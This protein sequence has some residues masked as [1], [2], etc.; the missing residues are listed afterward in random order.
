MK[1]EH[2]KEL[3]TN[4]LADRMG[5]LITRMKG[6]PSRSTVLTCILGVLVVLALLFFL[7]TRNRS[8]TAGSALWVALDGGHW[9]RQQESGIEITNLIDLA[10]SQG[11]TNAGKAARM[12]MAY[13]QLWE[14]GI[15]LLP[16][17][18][19][20]GLKQIRSAQQAYRGLAEELKDDPVLGPE[21]LYSVA[22]AE[23]SQAIKDTD[24]HLIEATRLYR[25][26]A[27]RYPESAHG[28]NARE[29]AEE[30]D[31]EAGRDRIRLFYLNMASQPGIREQLRMPL[32]LEKE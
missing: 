25:E 1:A 26:V 22:V 29:R 30:L 32:D 12:Q 5:R 21:A 24:K 7:Y 11:H 19:N 10:E 4:A 20:E 2:R 18:A 27:K 17:S 23:E 28:R 3:Q 14:F 16:V 9:K 31:R 13:F 15:K 6:G 8:R